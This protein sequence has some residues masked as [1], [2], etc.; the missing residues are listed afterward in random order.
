MSESTVQHLGEGEIN[1]PKLVSERIH[2]A[3]GGVFAKIHMADAQLELLNSVWGQY[4]GAEPRP[5]SFIIHISPESGDHTIY[6]EVV[7]P[8]PPTL[9]VIVGD[10]LHNLR[11]ALDHLAWEL[12]KRAGGKP[13]RHTYFPICD[14]EK[15]WLQETVHR[16]RA[17]DRKSPLAGVEPSSAIW[18][19]IQA[20]QPYKGAAY[21]N[22]LNALRVLSNADKHRQLLISGLFP[23][24]DDFAA[25]LKWSP[26]A[27]LRE[28]K[29]LLGPDN[30]MKDGDKV[31]FLNF[32]PD[33]P[34]P[35]L[36]VEGE[37]AFDIAFSDRGWDSSRPALAELKAAINQYVEYAGALYM[38][39]PQFEDPAKLTDLMRQSGRPLPK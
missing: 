37:L 27:V 8:P 30:P 3:L 31:A 18:R 20:V 10:V 7:E 23:D 22:S 9:S 28:Q 13:G 1:D 5:Y 36:G 4:L 29:I 35:Q 2:S 6:A 14:T 21:A 17:E 34:D 38:E 16:R 39:P 33:K 24:P 32:D 25:L 12:V 15:W 11:S 26:E 19:F